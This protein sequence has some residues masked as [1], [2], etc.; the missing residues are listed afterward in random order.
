MILSWPLSKAPLMNQTTAE[1]TEI[2]LPKLQLG[3]SKTNSIHK[4]LDL[5]MSFNMDFRFA[6]TNDIISS[7]SI[8]ATPVMV[9]V[10]ILKLTI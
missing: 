6:E 2:R 8:S 5:T 3:I 9:L 4:D 1:T 10:S 7:E